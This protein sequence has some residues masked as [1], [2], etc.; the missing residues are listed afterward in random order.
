LNYVDDPITEGGG[1]GALYF[2][3]G[4]GMT[5]NCTFI[6]PISNLNNDIYNNGGEVTFACA[7]GE[8]GTPVQMQGTE[9]AVIPPKELKCAVG[10]CF[11][12]DSRCVVDPTAALPC[13]KCETPGACV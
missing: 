7:D 10:N 3:G 5:K 4:A 8:V 13:A 9:I 2:D 11:C 12:R 6:G 1:G